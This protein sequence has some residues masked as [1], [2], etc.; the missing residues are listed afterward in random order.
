MVLFLQLCSPT[1]A[2]RECACS[3]LANLVFD[4]GA[5]P[6]LLNQDVVRR[7]GPLLLDNQR[8]IQEAAAGAL[9]YKD[10]YCIRRCVSL[11]YIN[12]SVTCICVYCRNLSLGGGPEVCVKMVEQDVMTP[13]TTFIHQV[14][15]Q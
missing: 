7:L 5:I 12:K 14:H 4:A 13:L 8:S 3:S 2:E 15:V 10:P 6:V 11:I 9:R 1:P